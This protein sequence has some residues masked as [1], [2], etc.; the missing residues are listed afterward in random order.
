MTRLAIWSITA[1][2]FAILMLLSPVLTRWHMAMAL[3]RSLA[4]GDCDTRRRAEARR[5]GHFYARVYPDL[6]I[7]TMTVVVFGLQAFAP[8]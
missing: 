7:A 4:R 3:R 1:G 6:V 2:L 8:R 5:L